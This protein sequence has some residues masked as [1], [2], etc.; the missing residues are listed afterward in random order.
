MRQVT[1][2]ELI[3]W[4]MALKLGRDSARKRSTNITLLLNITRFQLKVGSMPSML[5]KNW[6]GG[7]RNIG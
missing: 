2:T 1:N 6:F 4:R 7:L 3:S 5:S